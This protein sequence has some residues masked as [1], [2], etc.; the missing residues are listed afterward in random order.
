M[1]VVVLMICEASSLVWLGFHSHLAS[2][3]TFNAA[4]SIETTLIRKKERM[5]V[6]IIAYVPEIIPTLPIL[7]DPQVTKY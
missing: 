2:S 4:K 7:S 5:Y 6:D 3:A 1:N